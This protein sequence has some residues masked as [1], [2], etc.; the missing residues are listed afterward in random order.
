MA[1]P[2]MNV[3][4]RNSSFKYIA[5]QLDYE[6]ESYSKTMDSKR[7]EGYLLTG[8]M[9]RSGLNCDIIETI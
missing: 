1:D 6:Y 2:I 7:I 4:M 9:V 8:W 5:T 3:Y